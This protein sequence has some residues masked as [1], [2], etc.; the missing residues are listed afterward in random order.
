MRINAKGSNEEEERGKKSGKERKWEPYHEKT[1]KAEIKN[2]I[3][4]EVV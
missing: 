2:E 4:G 3:L 1:N